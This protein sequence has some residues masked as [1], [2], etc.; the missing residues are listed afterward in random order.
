M[1]KMNKYI[2]LHST[3]FLYSFC[4]V[5]SKLAAD[6]NMLSFKFILFYGISILILGIYA[7]VWQQILKKFTLTTAFLNKSVTII[8]GM[9]WGV[10]FFGEQIKWNMILGA[11]IVLLGISLV[12]KDY[13]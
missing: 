13:E 7:I 3:L 9:I 2:L 5:F 8:W 1:I 11:T 4:S 12:V 6:N 10:L